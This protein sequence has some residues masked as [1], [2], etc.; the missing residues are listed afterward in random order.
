MV[1]SQKRQQQRCCQT[2]IR[3]H[4]SPNTGS[5]EESR[6]VVAKR[7]QRSSI[8]KSCAFQTHCVL[9]VGLESILVYILYISF[10]VSMCGFYCCSQANPWDREE[11][12]D[13]VLR[14]EG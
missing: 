7:A 2:K 3:V 12:L 10:V 13:D 8:A 6:R 4:R 9:D 5:K 1:R 11:R 14:G